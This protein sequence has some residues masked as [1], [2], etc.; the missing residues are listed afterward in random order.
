[1]RAPFSAAPFRVVA[2]VM[3]LAQTWASFVVGNLPLYLVYVVRVDVAALGWLLA[4]LIGTSLV[5]RLLCTPLWQRLLLRV[6]PARA[7][8]CT[9]AAEGALLPL[10]FVLLKDPGAVG[11]SVEAVMLGAALVAGVAECPNDMIHHSLMGWAIDE[12]AQRSASGLRREGMFYACNGMTQHL[13]EALLALLLAL[14][15]V[16]GLDSRRCAD[17]QPQV[18]IRTPRSHRSSTHAVPT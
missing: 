14:L 5:T 6:H 2:G 13:S 18:T 17:E 8:A 15:G 11:L 1:M 10:L 4:L 16:A 9:R 12:D 3:F 7:Y